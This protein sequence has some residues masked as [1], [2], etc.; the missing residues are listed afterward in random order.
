MFQSNIGASEPINKISARC[1][2]NGKIT[3]GQLTLCADYLAFDSQQDF[4]K[5]PLIDVKK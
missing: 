4:F 3:D 5:I 1:L 2:K